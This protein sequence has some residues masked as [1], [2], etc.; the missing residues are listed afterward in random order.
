MGAFTRSCDDISK[1]RGEALAMQRVGDEVRRLREAKGMTLRQ[2]GAKVDLSA[3]YLSDVEH[4][5]RRLSRLTKVAKALG[6]KAIHFLHIAGQCPHCNG[7]GFAIGP[8]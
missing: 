5:R 2:L 1:R 7:S 6:V 3:P 8:V 4:G